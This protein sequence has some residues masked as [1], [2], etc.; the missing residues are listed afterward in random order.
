MVREVR[1]KFFDLSLNKILDSD[2]ASFSVFNISQG[3]VATQLR[4]GGI[5]INNFIAQFQLSTSVKELW[6]SVNVNI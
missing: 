3:S 1:W 5:F 2:I 6:K 4:G